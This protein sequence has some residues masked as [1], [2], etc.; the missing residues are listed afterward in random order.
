MTTK[1]GGELSAMG[2]FRDGLNHDIKTK[3]ERLRANLEG[4][5]REIERALGN[6]TAGNRVN[7]GGVVLHRGIDIDHECVVLNELYDVRI[8]LTA[9]LAH[10]EK[11]VDLGLHRG[12][13]KGGPK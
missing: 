3:E 6:L 11:N 5:K 1:D 2:L 13:E 7:R 4:L 10:D 12:N 9:A 8:S